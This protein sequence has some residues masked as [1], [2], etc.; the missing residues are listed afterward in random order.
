[1]AEPACFDVVAA[2]SMQSNRTVR[3]DMATEVVRTTSQIQLFD[4]INIS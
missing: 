2:L 4:P 3:H 1:M